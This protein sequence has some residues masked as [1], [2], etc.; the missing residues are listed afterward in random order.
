MADS[1]LVT[2]AD[3]QL[4]QGLAQRVTADRLDLVNDDASF[5]ELAWIWGKDHASDGES[6]PRRLW[7]SGHELVAWGWAYLPHR[8]KRSDGSVKDVTSAYLTYQVHPDR[9]ELIDEVIDWYEG[10]TAGVERTV[11][12]QAADEFAL[13]RWSAHGF[14][15]DPAS[16]GDTGSWTQLNRRDLKDLEEPVLPA[17]FLFRTAD[18]A[19]P[20]AA[21][22][23][24]V[25]A[26]APSTYTAEGYEGVRQ[27]P[28][29]RGDL[30]VLVEA[31][32]GTM[33]ASTIMW[34]DEANKTA[35]LEPVG[36]HPG[37]RRLGLGRAMLLHGMHRAREAGANHMTVA[38]LGAPG[39]P[40]ARGLYYS[41]GFRAFTRD[42]PL[43]KAGS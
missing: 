5:G 7:F 6:W 32:D 4:M 22:Q 27:T 17:G 30:H 14:Q 23:A 39:H 29:Y 9:S 38:C 21:V 42:V 12:P 13:E 16:L 37:Y 24:H 25:D 36:T 19:G 26:W 20:Q 43:I 41:V 40:A 2:A 11:A 35:Q 10:V 15:A 18:E 28:A 3:V 8:V 33:A 34:L 31:P 1:S